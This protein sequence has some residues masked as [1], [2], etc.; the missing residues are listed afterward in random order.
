NAVADQPAGGAVDGG[1]LPHQRAEDRPE[2]VDQRVQTD[3]IS[4]G[5]L[6]WVVVE[7]RFTKVGDVE[8]CYETFGHEGNP[9][10]LLIMGLGTQM[11]AWPEE[12][13]RMLAARGFYVIRYD[14]RDVGRSTHFDG[15]PTPRQWELLRRRPKR[16]AYSLGDMA[17][18]AVGLLDALRIE[19][20]HVVGASM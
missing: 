20:A 8:L 2:S 7:E 13:C 11:I 18:D 6:F 19:R 10:M 4:T 17:A 15:A 9:A 3:I 14:N 16:V 5:T 12:F 1:V